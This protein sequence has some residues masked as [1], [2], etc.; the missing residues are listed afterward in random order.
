MAVML[1]WRSGPEAGAATGLESAR[2]TVAG[3][4]FRA[5]GRMIRGTPE[6]VLTASYRLVVAADGALSRLAVDVATAEGEQQLTISR[7][8]DG[9][10]LVDDG[11]GGTRGAFSGARDVDLAFSPVFNALPIRRLG[12]HRDPA[13][14]VLPMVFVDLPTLAV[15][16]TEQTYRTVRSASAAGPAVV[17]F[18]AG[19]VAADMT[20]DADGFVLDYPGIATRV[21]L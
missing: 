2:I 21:D 9:V 1:S 12:L 11:S 15:E 14:H 7:S 17:G 19:D 8:T 6:G 20:V 13:E 18:A 3:G 10:W 4:G 16:A 5:V